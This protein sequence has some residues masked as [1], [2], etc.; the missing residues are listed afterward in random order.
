MYTGLETEDFLKKEVA[1]GGDRTH[2]LSISFIFSFF[3]HFTAEP[4]R[5]P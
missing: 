3:H 1:R 2:I 4:Q 5:L